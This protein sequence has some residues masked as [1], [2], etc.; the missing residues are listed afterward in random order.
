MVGFAGYRDRYGDRAYDRDRGGYERDRGKLEP[1]SGRG[2]R[3]EFNNCF[4]DNYIVLL[5]FFFLN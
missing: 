2:M 4:F 1:L 3:P 5:L